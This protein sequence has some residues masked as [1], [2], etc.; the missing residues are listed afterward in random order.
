MEAA[1]ES[2]RVSTEQ[3]LASAS[4]A[5]QQ[6]PIRSRASADGR[7][8]SLASSVAAG[9][10]AASADSGSVLDRI[11][12]NFKGL[13]GPGQGAAA[14]SPQR[15]ASSAVGAANG[16]IGGPPGTPSSR[17]GQALGPGGLVSPSGGGGGAGALDVFVLI[18]G[19][20]HKSGWLCCFTLTTV[21]HVCVMRCGC[22]CCSCPCRGLAW[23]AAGGDSALGGADRAYMLCI[24]IRTWLCCRFALSSGNQA[25]G[26]STMAALGDKLASAALAALLVY[27]S[28]TC[29]LQAGPICAL[30]AKEA[31]SSLL[32]PHCLEAMKSSQH[33]A[34]PTDDSL[35]RA[36]ESAL[37]VYHV[38]YFVQA[39]RHQAPMKQSSTAARRR[40]RSGRRS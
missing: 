26:I 7:A 38:F 34:V 2:Q 27:N 31:T 37:S 12:G 28:T 25:P 19:F 32:A 36:C 16:S 11:S 17:G 29:H 1:L 39:H 14:G 20:G 22:S 8:G 21:E 10:A 40:R 6:T 15:P 4:K 35:P 9:G 18:R 30:L 3:Q 23:G 5:S 33:G 24:Y 13:L